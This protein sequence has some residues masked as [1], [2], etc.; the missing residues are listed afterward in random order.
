MADQA[1]CVGN[2][3]SFL[4]SHVCLNSTVKNNQPDIVGTFQ[5]LVNM[6]PH[7]DH[8][9]ILPTPPNCKAH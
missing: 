2:L 6:L 3:A 8:S 5:A 1:E 4:S 7:L 9:P